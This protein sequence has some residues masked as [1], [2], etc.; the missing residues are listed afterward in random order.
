MLKLLLH[1]F[2]LSNVI[3]ASQI[4]S[5]LDHVPNHGFNE[6]YATTA[7]HHSL[8]S[9][10]KNPAGTALLNK[11]SISSG[12]SSH[13]DNQYFSTELTVVYPL[14]SNTTFT[15]YLPTRI[16]SNINAYSEN[17]SFVKQY[18]D[19]E[20]LLLLNLSKQ[21]SHNISIGASFNIFQSKI[22]DYSQQETKLDLGLQGSFKQLSYGISVQNLN[23][24]TIVNTGI[25]YS[26]HQHKILFDIRMMKERDAELQLGLRYALTPS[27]SL[28]YG[29]Q[30][31]TDSF[32][33][34]IGT[35]IELHNFTLSYNYTHHKYLGL[36]HRIGL[37]LDF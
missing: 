9:L 10:I 37:K 16:V 25:S 22:L 18:N 6:G 15:F 29:N 12:Y 34:R 31:V 19:I 30:N 11:K 7:A 20:Q 5:F 33:P 21:L 36:T 2:F 17:G 3:I 26:I 23:D 13:F 32:S 27:L 4:L 8:S 14:K 28:I 1:L 35:E 24:N